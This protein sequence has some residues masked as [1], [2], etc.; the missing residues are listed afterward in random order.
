MPENGEKKS[1]TGS[2]GKTVVRQKVAF[3]KHTDDTGV[4]LVVDGDDRRV[5]DVPHFGAGGSCGRSG[6]AGRERLIG[7]VTKERPTKKE[8]RDGVGDVGRDGDRPGG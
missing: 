2:V 1:F 8:S 7:R 4:N 5:D 6:L 3:L